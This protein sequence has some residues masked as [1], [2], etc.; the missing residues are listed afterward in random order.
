MKQTKI[1]RGISLLLCLLLSLFI[2]T[3]SALAY[4]RIDTKRAVALTI[5]VTQDDPEHEGQTISLPGVAF[6]LYRIADVDETAS[7]TMARAFVGCNVNFNDIEDASD[8]RAA[9]ELL[10]M[11]ITRRGVPASASAVSNASGRLTFKLSRPGLFL[12]LGESMESEGYVYRFS[13]IVVS[14]PQLEDGTWKYE[15]VTELKMERVEK[16]FDLSVI[17]S[18]RNDT[19]RT[20][21]RP[22]SITINLKRDGEVVSSVELT[23]RNGWRCTFTNLTAANDWTIEEAVVPPNYSV[24]YGSMVNDGDSRWHII[25]T[26]TCTT[27]PPE[28]PQTGLLWWPVPVLVFAG[29]VLLAA[30]WILSRKGRNT[31]E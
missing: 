9:A 29:L 21:E 22:E 17:K 8:M 25:V 12:V 2:C 10:Q 23:A 30:G 4:D 3:T 1:L 16:T 7:Y 13:P 6:R 19:G 24:T 28:I 26:N 20:N 27:P 18:W 15:Q 11:Y 14:L 31:H 5:N